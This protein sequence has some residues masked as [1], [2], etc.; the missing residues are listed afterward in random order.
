M[1]FVLLEVFQTAFRHEAAALFDEGFPAFPAG[2]AG[3]GQEFVFQSV[4]SRA[5]RGHVGEGLHGSED[6]TRM[7]RLQGEGALGDGKSGGRGGNGGN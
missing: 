2:V 3:R 5:T 4:T 1:G 7:A 6:V